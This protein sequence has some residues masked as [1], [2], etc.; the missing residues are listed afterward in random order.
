[1]AQANPLQHNK[2]LNNLGESAAINFRPATI[3][4]ALSISVLAMQVFL[5]TYAT[6]GMR[7]DLAREALGIYDTNVLSKTIA[8]VPTSF[9]VAD[10][11]TH[12]VGF[13]ELA[14]TADAPLSILANGL[15]CKKLYVQRHFKRMGIGQELLHNA[16]QI[17]TA[18][19]ASCVWLT[20]YIANATAIRF[21]EAM[22]YKD[23]G[24]T[25]YCFEGVAYE[26]IIFAKILA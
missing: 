23:I 4:D 8:S 3:A 5:D 17:A 12:L 22:G 15:E 13:T 21:Y 16:E 26:N 6:D 25:D 20:A 1:M 19:S 10:R 18:S 7:A 9:I 14:H 2:T 24:R 11:N